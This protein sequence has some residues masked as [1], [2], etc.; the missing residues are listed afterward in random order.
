MAEAR[1]SGLYG[2]NDRVMQGV[3]TCVWPWSDTSQAFGSPPT[4][5]L[6]Q[7]HASGDGMRRS[8]AP[9]WQRIHLV[10]LTKPQAIVLLKQIP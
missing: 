1:G 8:Q 4:F 2:R 10:I 5:L 7:G 6:C 9:T 3:W